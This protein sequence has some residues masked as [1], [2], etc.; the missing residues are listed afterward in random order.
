LQAKC[1]TD[2]IFFDFRK[3][4]DSVCHSKLL[5]KLRSYGIHDNLFVWIEAFLH[6]R[7]QSV[8]IG[9]A[10]SAVTPVIS[11]VPQGSV[12]GSTLFLLYINDIADIFN[13][14]SVWAMTHTAINCGN[15]MAQLSCAI[16]LPV[17][18]S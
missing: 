8:R 18:H 15:I 10:I 5:A 9:E 6:G 3:A 1:V 11:G 16:I 2:V 7:S 4:F 12:L 13:D 14:L 17:C